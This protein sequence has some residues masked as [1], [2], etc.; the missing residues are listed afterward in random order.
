M[1]NRMM[2]V[3][4]L[5]LAAVLGGIEHASARVFPSHPLSP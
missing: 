5:A 2:F 3:A 4:S 1:P